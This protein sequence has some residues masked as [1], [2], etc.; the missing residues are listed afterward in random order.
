MGDGLVKTGASG[1]Q[2]FRPAG[3]VALS[4]HTLEAAEKIAARA[5]D[6]TALEAA[7]F[8]KLS[9]QRD[10]AA[11]YRAQHPHGSNQ[12]GVAS[13][14]NSSYEEDCERFG[15]SYRTVARWAE[16]LLDEA[17]FQIE[18]HE[19][20][21]KVW[22]ILGMEQAAN[23]SSES[24]E[25]YTPPRYI[26][27]VRSVLGEIDLDPA[28]SALANK[29]VGAKA[30]YALK[31]DGLA[32]AW[33]GRVFLNPPY[34]RTAAGD[35]MA[36]A[37]CGKAISEHRSGRVP[38]CV[39]LVNSVHSQAWQAPLYDFVICLVDHRIQFCAADGEENKSPTFQNLFAYLG[40]NEGRFSEVFGALGYV[41]KRMP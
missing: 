4:I 7:V 8:G 12:H 25:W 14:G 41:M 34:G 36:A 1:L 33:R 28:S 29:T 19:R 32:K 13:A 39:I 37:F 11:W 10:F 20:M 30:F 23:F 6:A 2:K 21:I 3:E 24:V 16:R 31:D 9:A 27:A 38:E 15:F 18:K 40:P 5:K 22:R 17:G 26:E 35:S